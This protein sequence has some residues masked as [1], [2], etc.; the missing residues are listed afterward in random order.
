MSTPPAIDLSRLTG[1]DMQVIFEI[2]AAS[3]SDRARLNLDLLDRAIDGGLESIA[4][5]DVPRYLE[6]LSSAVAELF[7]PKP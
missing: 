6:A 2:E 4:L 7:A 1:K 5:P 3:G